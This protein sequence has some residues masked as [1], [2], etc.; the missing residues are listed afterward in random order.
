MSFSYSCMK[1]NNFLLRIYAFLRKMATMTSQVTHFI[2]HIFVLFS[3][4]F[5]FIQATKLLVG[6]LVRWSLWAMWL[7][8]SGLYCLL[9]GLGTMGLSPTVWAVLW[10]GLQKI[11]VSCWKKYNIRSLFAYGLSLSMWM[12]V[13]WLGSSC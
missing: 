4:S 6:R 8:C 12:Y 11:V 13:K 10:I 3:P 9:L 1:L 2:H 7:L 5:T